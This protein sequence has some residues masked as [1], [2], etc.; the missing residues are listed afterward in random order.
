[1]TQRAGRPGERRGAP[2][3]EKERDET[4]SIHPAPAARPPAIHCAA[5]FTDGRRP[6]VF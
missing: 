6:I 1:M 4:F 5:R 3:K 2:G